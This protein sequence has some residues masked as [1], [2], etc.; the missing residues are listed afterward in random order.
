[1][2]ALLKLGVM[3]LNGGDGTHGA[4]DGVGT[5]LGRAGVSGAPRDFD[6]EVAIALGR[7]DGL[8]LG[9]LADHRPIGLEA[10]FDR[11]PGSDTRLLLVHAGGE[12]H[13]P[14]RARQ[15]PL[16]GH[17]GECHAG[18]ARLHIAGTAAV[19]ATIVDLAGKGIAR[20]AL[21]D[22]HR[23]A[24]SGQQQSRPVVGAPEASE[25]RP[26]GRRLIQLHRQAMVG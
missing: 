7:A 18:E 26:F 5:A 3:G 19:E 13:A 11:G 9:G 1:M 24:V 6:L 10:S 14:A 15:S 20:P 23:V 8:K 2:A 12:Q 16:Q 21:A 25:V 17:H 4:I 22:G